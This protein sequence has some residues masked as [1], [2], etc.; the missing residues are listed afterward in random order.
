MNVTHMSM[1]QNKY[2]IIKTQNNLSRRQA[3]WLEVLQANDFEVKYCPGK[4]NVVAV[5]AEIGVGVA[6]A[7]ERAVGT[8]RA[9]SPRDRAARNAGAFSSIPT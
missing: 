7:E 9:D 2:Y 5:A 3:R 8:F 4:T 1:N 6:G